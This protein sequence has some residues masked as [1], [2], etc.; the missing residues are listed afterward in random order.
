MP[1]TPPPRSRLPL[2]LFG[3]FF[4][5][6]LAWGVWT[7]MNWGEPGH[8]VDTSPEAVVQPTDG[9]IPG[10]PAPTLPAQPDNSARDTTGDASRGE[11]AVRPAP[12]A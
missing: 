2:L 9:T 11:S 5:V 7:W 8:G 12:A 4:L 3:G 6:I 1:D 10:T